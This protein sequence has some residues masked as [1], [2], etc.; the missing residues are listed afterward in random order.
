M[1]LPDGRKPVDSGRIDPMSI[2]P[3]TQAVGLP[4][5]ASPGES[6][7]PTAVRD[8]PPAD[9]TAPPRPMT[10]ADYNEAVA[11]R[12][13]M[14]RARGLDAP[15]I[16]GGRDPHP[17]ATA[18]SERRSMQLL[19]LMVALIVAGGFIISIVGFIVTGGR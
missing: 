13:Q 6:S 3:T 1:T 5:A 11:P 18:R 10:M 17:E 8:D 9:A 15:Y 12:G 2:D 16:P 19:I 7:N 14:A 4:A